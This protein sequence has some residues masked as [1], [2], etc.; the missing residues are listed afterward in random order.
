MN[1]QRA[2]LASFATVLLASTTAGADPTP[3]PAPAPTVEV[4]PLPAP[5]QPAVDRTPAPARANK[6]AFSAGRFVVEMLAGGVVGG[7]AGYAVFSGLGGDNFGA[8]IAGLG[9]NIA[10]TP[11][12]VYGTGRAMGGQGSVGSAYLGGLLAFSGPS[13]TPDQA[14]LSFAI[15]M[16]LMPVTSSLMYEISSHVRSK[17]F[18]TVARGVSVAPVVG[19]NGVSG[20]RVGLG[21]A[22]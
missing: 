18:E 11:L 8:A 20:A 15:G 12:V 5:A 6:G 3:P 19:N 21:F 9:A 4:A 2:V 22:F 7:L 17:R 10:V 1:T 16:A 13:A 14:A